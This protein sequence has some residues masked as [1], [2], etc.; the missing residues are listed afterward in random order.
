M[1]GTRV[2]LATCIIILAAV[3]SAH[4]WSILDEVTVIDSTYSAQL[5]WELVDSKPYCGSNPTNLDRL[6]CEIAP[7][8][9]QFWIGIDSAGNRFGTI[10][11]SD[12]NGEYF[13]IYRRLVGTNFDTHIVRVTKRV[14]PVFG[15]VTKLKVASRWEVDV[16]NGDLLITVTG[17]CLSSTCVTQSDTLDHLAM[18][19]ITGLPPLLA[20]AATYEPPASVAF[21][22]PTRPEGLPRPRATPLASRRPVSLRVVAGACRVRSALRVPPASPLSGD[23]YLPRLE[24]RM[25][26]ANFRCHN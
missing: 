16:T 26:T 8:P 6:A 3:G 4:G 15:E 18:I 24:K 2:S 21:R 14:E 25:P 7:D 10:N 9:A 19:K 17:N 11:G 5:V 12:P 23:Q 22:M 20:L 1:H 13:D